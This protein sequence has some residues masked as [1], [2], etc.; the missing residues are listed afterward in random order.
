MKSD[1]TR[2]WNSIEL[3]ALYTDKGGSQTQSRFLVNAIR[4]LLKPDLIVLSSPGIASI[5]LFKTKASEQF[6]I[7]YEEDDDCNAG[8]IKSLSK[9][10]KAECVKPDPLT[11]ATRISMDDVNDDC[12]DTLKSLLAVDTFHKRSAA[13][14]DR[15]ACMLGRQC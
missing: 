15:Y 7:V 3:N 6:H 10:I 5:V 12:S 1:T 11:Y 9:A 13:V 8:A 4:E 14:P 2:I